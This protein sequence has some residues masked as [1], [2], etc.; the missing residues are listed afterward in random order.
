MT[1]KTERKGLGR[2]LSALLADT[3]PLE[4]AA[5]PRGSTGQQ[6]IP[7]ERIRANP[8]QP[9]RSFGDA[10]LD[11]LARSIARSG[12]IQPLILRRDPGDPNLFQIVAGER[13]WRAAQRARIHE[14]PAVIRDFSDEE[15]LE[16]AIVENIQRVDL[17]AV[18]EAQ[19]YRQLME[20]FGHTQEALAEALGKS[21]SHIANMLRL[22]GLP[23]SVLAHLRA[24]RL[25]AGHARALITAEDPAALA[26][27]VI[28]QQ[29]SVRQTEA[30]TKKTS[31]SKNNKKQSLKPEKDADTRAIEG[32]LS[33]H[34]KMPVR[35]EHA[36]AGDGGTLR[37]GYRSLDD[38]DRLLQILSGS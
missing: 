1:R 17:N 37:I 13:R 28:S 38:L 15:V 32:D 36:S 29:L 22:L 34:L 26:Q 35:I 23:E 6:M 4:E 3:G 9:R 20:S 21:R 18:E 27:I 11:E 8:D 33:A 2:G 25:S 19:G 31:E 5:S 7:I 16:V 14:V 12:I 10:E 30:L 24:G